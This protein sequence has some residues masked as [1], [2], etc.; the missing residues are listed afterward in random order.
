MKRRNQ[1]FL[2]AQDP[3][4]V[5]RATKIRCEGEP[6]QQVRKGLS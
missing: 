2:N 4:V 6:E 1:F 3:I 5:D